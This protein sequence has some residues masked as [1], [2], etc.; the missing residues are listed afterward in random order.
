M[1]PVDLSNNPESSCFLTH[2][3][4]GRLAR[5]PEKRR[6]SR[7][8]GE[9]AP[10]EQ[11]CPT[12]VQSLYTARKPESRFAQH[13]GLMTVNRFGGIRKVE[14][15]ERN[16]L[17]LWPQLFPQAMINLLFDLQCPYRKDIP[18]S[19]QQVSRAHADS[20]AGTGLNV[21]PYSFGAPCPET[22]R[23]TATCTPR[24][25]VGKAPLRAS[26]A[27]IA[28]PSYVPKLPSSYSHSI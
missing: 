12:I 20:Q 4:D 1:N 23:N 19:P 13:R 27:S 11:D 10:F 21:A 9:H 22:C 14:Y 7:M 3:P 24:A 6:G 5:K 25:F 17:G 28:Q 18:K 8:G 16:S 26:A 15:L 2:N